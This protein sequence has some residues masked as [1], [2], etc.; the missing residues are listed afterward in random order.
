MDE[1]T[2][3]YGLLTIQVFNTNFCYSIVTCIHITCIEQTWL[4]ALNAVFQTIVPSSSFLWQRW[5]SKTNKNEPM[6]LSEGLREV[7]FNQLY[8]Y[9]CHIG[10]VDILQYHFHSE[11]LSH[12]RREYTE[13]FFQSSGSI[14]LRLISVGDRENLLAVESS[15]RR[16]NNF[17]R[18]LIKNKIRRI[19]KRESVDQ[20]QD[21]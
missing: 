2:L 3:I 20:I 9:S 4:L 1:F 5:D 14:A 17:I 21:F 12:W 19:S 10:G 11:P 15:F 7:F 16:L 18:F 6:H 13:I 8:M